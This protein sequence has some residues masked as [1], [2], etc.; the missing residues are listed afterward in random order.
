MKKVNVINLH[1]KMQNISKAE[2]AEFDLSVEELQELVEDIPDRRI[3][4][5]KLKD[6]AKGYNAKNIQIRAV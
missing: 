1:Q 3:V 6:W 5:I 2:N 4:S